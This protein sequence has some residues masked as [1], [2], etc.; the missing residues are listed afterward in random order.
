M[1]LRSVTNAA[2]PCPFSSCGMPTTGGL[3]D[4]FVRDQRAF[5]FGGAEPMAETFSTSSIRP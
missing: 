3:G 1:P 5:D 4:G 2:T